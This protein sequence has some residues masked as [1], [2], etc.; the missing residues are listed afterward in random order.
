MIFVCLTHRL[1]SYSTSS[2]PPTFSPAHRCASV[3]FVPKVLLLCTL[4]STILK[5]DLIVNL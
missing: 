4:T 3:W 5:K 2:V 1:C